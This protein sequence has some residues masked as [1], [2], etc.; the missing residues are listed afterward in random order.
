M[1]A[2]YRS[3]VE[4]GLL[5]RRTNA[6]RYD[7]FWDQ[8]DWRLPNRVL[9]RIWRLDRS[10]VRARRLRLGLDRP[11]WCTSYD[12]QLPSFEAALRA[13]E[14]KAGR[15]TGRRPDPA[16]REPDVCQAVMS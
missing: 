5:G 12:F 11:R 13:E 8:L 7:A 9:A 3:A 15:F 10:N 2:A 1:T 6:S 16:C 14:A 4:I